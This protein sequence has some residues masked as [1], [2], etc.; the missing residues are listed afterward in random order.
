MKKC[1]VGPCFGLLSTKKDVFCKK[2]SAIF[3]IIGAKS[4]EYNF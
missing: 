2:Q 1:D 3:N 4:F